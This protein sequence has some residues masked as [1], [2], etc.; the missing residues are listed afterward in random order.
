MVT[1]SSR[2]RAERTWKFQWFKLR[3]KVRKLK[4]D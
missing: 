1:E 3:V 4:G 2:P